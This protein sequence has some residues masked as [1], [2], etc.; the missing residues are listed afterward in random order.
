[1]NPELQKALADAV[2]SLNSAAQQIG[3]A[4]QQELPAILRE[5]IRD[6]VWAYSMGLALALLLAIF[7]WAWSILLMRAHRRIEEGDRYYGDG[8]LVA[9]W[10]GGISASVASALIFCFN[11]AAL[12]HVLVA[13][14]VYLI[15]QIK[16]LVK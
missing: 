15:E 12:V 9:A 8:A 10:A 3:T 16:A 5:Y 11:A 4:A 14:R 2:A 13:P 1:M 6:A 7:A